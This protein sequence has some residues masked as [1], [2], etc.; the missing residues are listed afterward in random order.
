MIAR[1]VERCAKLDLL[2]RNSHTVRSEAKRFLELPR[3][4]Q[5][6]T[7]GCMF[8]PVQGATK[9]NAGKSRKIK[10]QQNQCEECGL[11]ILG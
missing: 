4:A 2:A 9:H 5:V 10:P 7:L 8:H 6:V 3:R 11:T 1:V